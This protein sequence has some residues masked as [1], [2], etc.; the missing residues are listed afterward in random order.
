VIAKVKQAVAG[1]QTF[2]SEVQA[3]LKKCN[4]PTRPELLESTV[5]VIVSCVILGAVVAGSDL[6]LM[7]VMRLAIR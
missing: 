3:E 5:V 4:W 1:A 6:I 2:L 7:W